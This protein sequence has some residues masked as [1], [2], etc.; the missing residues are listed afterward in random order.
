M[1]PSPRPLRARPGLPFASRACSASARSRC[2][3]RR[4]SS[5][6]RRTSRPSSRSRRCCSGSSTSS[7][8]CSAFT[9]RTSTS[10]T[11]AGGCCAARQCTGCPRTSSASSFRRTRALRRRPSVAGGPVISSG[12]AAAAAIPHDAYA[13]FTSRIFAPIVDSGE[14]RGVLGAAAREER[15]F[16]E[17]DTDVIGAF[18]SLAAL[19]LRNAETYEERSRQARVQRGFSSIATVLGE[20]LSLTATL[21]AVAQAAAEALGGD[22]TA[23]LMPRS[24]GELE[25][26]GCVRAAAAVREQAPGRPSP[27]ARVLTLCAAEGRVIA[28]PSLAGDTRFGQEWTTLAAEAGCKA[29]LAV[30]LES[31]RSERHGV[32]LVCFAEE[33]RFTDDDLELASQLTHVARG[34][35]G[36]SDLYESERSARALAQQLARTGSLLATELDPDT[37]LEEVVQ[38]APPLLGADACAIRILEG[39]ELV[40]H[41]CEW[42]RRR[43][44]R[45]HAPA[46]HE[47]SR[48]RRLP[49]ADVGRARGR[50]RRPAARRSRSRDRVGLLGVPRRPARRPGG[51][52]P[53]R[54]VRLLA[55]RAHVAEGRD[56]GA[57]GACRKHVGGALERGALHV[58]RR[59]PRAQLRDPR[60]HR[61]RHRRR[62]Q[63]LARRALERRR[64]ADH[65]RRR[66]GRARPHGRGRPPPQPVGRRRPATPPRPDSARHGGG[67]A[68][69]HRGRDARS[70]ECRVGPHLRVPRHLVGAARGGDEER[71]RRDGVARAA[72]PAHVD[73]RLC[74]DAPARGRPL[75]RGGAAHVPALHRF[76]IGTA[77]L[78]RRCAPERRAARHRRPAGRPRADR[79]RLRRLGGRRRRPGS[80]D[81]RA[82]VRARSPRGA[83]VG[84]GRSRTSCARCCRRSSTT[85]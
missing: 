52:G 15:R 69:R 12:P 76:R 23:V 38:H 22:F 8:R 48:R 42:R 41:G 17:R 10:T 37:V 11:S 63:G 68:L 64:R 14:T 34:A 45:R 44:A 60:E 36:R 62:R 81:E 24:D 56:R 18:A 59:R 54:A 29:L 57:R 79:C 19:A 84:A 3:S 53:R 13:G 9:P 71:V 6:L 80:D 78:D 72:E 73:L 46:R 82:P 67:L 77:D 20:P 5:A 47:P 32:V 83:A 25:L 70:R 27:A 28:A 66:R 51:N 1:S 21:D 65:R 39:D 33:R 40:A 16:G 50:S 7:P 4:A 75:R 74:R 43:G 31:R 2:A 58:G 85:P 61:G 35:L 55:T 30:P 26:G 49:V